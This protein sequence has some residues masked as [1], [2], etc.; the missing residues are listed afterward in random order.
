MRIKF[1]KGFTPER[2]AENLVTIIRENDWLIGTVNIYVQTYDENMKTM[3]DQGEYVVCKPKE[4]AV[5]EYDEDAAE[6]RRGRLKAIN[7]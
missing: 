4:K 7:E 1:E 6:I 5:L 3:D 2:I